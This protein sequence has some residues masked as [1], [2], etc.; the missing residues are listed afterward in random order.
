M[1]EPISANLKIT[2]LYKDV[3][4]ASVNR[5]RE[6]R[7]QYPYQE[8]TLGGRIWRYIDSKEGE[9][10]LF[11][12]AGGTTIAEVS[13]NSIAHFA[14]DYLLSATIIVTS[15]SND[16]ECNN[17]HYTSTSTFTISSSTGISC[18]SSIAH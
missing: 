7:H 3:P 11:I 12:P 9:Q 2:N 16:C 8:V 14:K 13:F 17:S 5:L 4:E 10:V 6:F 15:T 18:C 1:T